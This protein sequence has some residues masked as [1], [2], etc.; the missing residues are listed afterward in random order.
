MPFGKYKG[1]NL[2]DIYY[3]EEEGEA[4]LE[5]CLENLSPGDAKNFIESYLLLK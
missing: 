2:N 5:W 4:Y 1:E 3:N